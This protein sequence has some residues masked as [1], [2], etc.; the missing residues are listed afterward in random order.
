GK[1][2]VPGWSYVSKEKRICCHVHCMWP[3]IF[4][5]WKQDGFHGTD[6]DDDNLT[7]ALSKI[8]LKGMAYS[9]GNGGR[10]RVEI[11]KSAGIF[12]RVIIGILLG[13]PTA[14]GLFL[15]N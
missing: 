9:Y 11:L 3:M 13:D 7:M 4:E 10:C 1:T 6:D 15:W 2:G 12:L 5:A 8:A 14:L